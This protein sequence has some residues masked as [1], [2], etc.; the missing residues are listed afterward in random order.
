LCKDST[1]EGSD[2]GVGDFKCECSFGYQGGGLNVATCADV[3][4]CASSPCQNGGQ[5]FD[6]TGHVAVSVGAFFCKCANGYTGGGFSEAKCEEI[7][8]RA[9]VEALCVVLVLIFGAC[10]WKKPKLCSSRR[11]SRVAPLSEISAIRQELAD[12]R[13][14][15]ERQRNS[16]ILAH[17][18]QM[19]EAISARR[20]RR[21]RLRERLL[22]RIAKLE[23]TAEVDLQVR[24]N[25]VQKL[26]TKIDLTKEELADVKTEL[27]AAKKRLR[28]EKK[29][30]AQQARA[31]A[32]RIVAT[33]ASAGISVGG[34]RG[35]G[36]DEGGRAVGLD[37]HG[38]RG[39][40]AFRVRPAVRRPR[41]APEGEG[42]ARARPRAAQAAPAV[43]G[44]R[45]S[46]GRSDAPHAAEHPRRR[47]RVDVEG[48]V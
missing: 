45:R 13:E 41:A 35:G 40:G 31:E 22:S 4:E 12:V 18:L 10:V 6:S 16:M 15:G 11:T 38:T 34:G 25:V 28:K 43:A 14:E 33:A 46:A 27:D 20:D 5:C 21:R 17:R 42:P 19:I 48:T 2:V 29:R 1:T 23:E 47:P 30:R 37:A 3:D 44:P 26:L 39:G 7:D 24:T 8:E 36:K 32:H 9:S